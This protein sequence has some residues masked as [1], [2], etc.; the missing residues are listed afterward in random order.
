MKKL[1]I[2]VVED[3]AD[4]RDFICSALMDPCSNVEILAFS[5]GKDFFSFLETSVKLPDLVVTDLRMPL[6]SGFDVIRQ[7]KADDATKETTVV[8]L[9]TSSNQDDIEK[10]KDLGA[11]G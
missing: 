9:S 7:I 6:I 1:V 8:M 2:A 3:D 10:A 4:D 5:G 11:A